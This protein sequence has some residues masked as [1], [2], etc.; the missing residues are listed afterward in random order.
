MRGKKR[1]LSVLLVF[2]MI[3]GLFTGQ[4]VVGNEASA[5]DNEKIV[6]NDLRK[7]ADNTYY[8]YPNAEVQ[9]PDASKRFY[10]LTIS[11]D[12]GH[13]TVD[14]TSIAGTTGHGI[15]AGND[16]DTSF[17]NITTDHKYEAIS[18]VFSSGVTKSDIENFIRQIKFTTANTL[19]TVYMC[20]ATKSSGELQTVVNGQT[21]ELKYFNGH[22]YGFVPNK[23][24]QKTKWSEAYKESKTATFNGV[25]G[26]LLTLTS[27]AE[28][29][30]I[31]FSFPQSEG[32]DYAKM[33][34]MG[35]TRAILAEGS[36]YSDSDTLWQP[37]AKFTGKNLADFHWRW[38][39]GPEAGQTFGY[40]NDAFGYTGGSSPDGGF[41]TKAGCFSNWNAVGNIEPNGGVNTDEAFGFY[42]KY[43]YGRWNDNE[44]DNPQDQIEGY[45]IE[46]GGND[47]DDEKFESGLDQIIV[48]TEGT[49]PEVITD[50]TY[51]EDKV[52]DL[53]GKPAIIPD[54]RDGKAGTVLTADI[55]GVGPQEALGALKYQWYTVE[56]NTEVPIPGAT[57]LSYKMKA[58]DEGKTFVVK[59]VGPESY[60]GTL[61]SDKLIPITDVVSIVNNNKD[62]DGK[63]IVKEGSVLTADI[64]GVNPSGSHDTLT[65]QWYIKDGESETPIEGAVYKNYT[66]TSDDVDKKLVVKVT[67][68]GN[69]YNTLSSTPYDATR[70]DADIKIDDPVTNPETDKL[71]IT[72]DSTMEDYVYTL[73]KTDG[74]P[75]DPATEMKVVNGDGDPLSPDPEGYY[76]QPTGGVIKFTELDK[77]NTYVI[78]KKKKGTEEEGTGGVVG[79]S[80]YDVTTDYDDKD[81]EDKSDDTISIIVDPALE[82]SVYAIRKK[83]DGTYVDIPIKKDENGNWIPDEGGEGKVPVVWTEGNENK[84]TFTNLPADGTYKVVAKSSDGTI[85]DVTP[86]DIIGGSKDIM[87]VHPGKDDGNTNPGQNPGQSPNPGSTPNAS[88]N[89]GGQATTTPA[90]QVF[91]K[92]E[93]DAA[94][95][96]V[97]EHATD[98]KGKI[99]TKITDMTRDIITSGENDW[100]KLTANEKAAVNARL[101]AGGSKYTYEQL[102]KMAKAYKVPGFKVIKFMQKKSKAKLK[103]IKCT[104]ATIVCTSTNSK[105]ATINKKGVISAKK[106]GRAT[107]TFTA[108]KGKYTNRLVIDVRVKKKFKNAKELTKFK[109][110]VIKTPTV[111]VAKKRLLKKSSKIQ[112]YDL[113]KSSKVK[114]TPINK[115]IL[116]INKKGK[117][118][119]KKKGSTLVKVTINQNKKV[120]LL[121]VYVTI[122]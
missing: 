95:K 31:L 18:F 35:C 82:D 68:N 58:E 6:L 69:Y 73:Q 118:T 98:P 119:G 92:T 43:R 93:Q 66:L 7:S 107:L 2:S 48:T 1:L 110:K 30:F 63:D 75:I 88:P 74:T 84:V 19:Q 4:V 79:P 89:P 33:G 111:L 91:T 3:A 78:V 80:V 14:S 116:T 44:G 56:G 90:N 114:F 45:Y 52:T 99:V 77:D 86:G 27:R 70:T 122:Y 103:L 102:L 11:V 15:V 17:G 113:E 16:M 60:P 50:G 115:K 72:I 26:Y 13:M 59:V 8:T 40:Q 100:K 32:S 65:Y 38:V 61:T 5:A 51:T 20:A 108:I 12:S 41:A 28:D 23:S 55:S 49:T 36:S 105:V 121:Y 71:T 39:S 22:Y 96:F 54:N 42:G 47:G 112:V 21:I 120:Y 85:S 97:K 10:N 25:N 9:I 81:T 57:D 83:V 37:L 64:S 106:V 67:G 46:F 34:W 24:W 29:R 62:K 117:Y 101:K 87:G 94:A 76:E 53:T 109:S 104:G